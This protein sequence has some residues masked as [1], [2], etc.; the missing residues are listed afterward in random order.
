VN[1]SR[2]QTLLS[3]YLDHKLDRQVELAM[4]QHLE[5]CSKCQTTV[6]DVRELREDLRYFPEAQVS[7]ELIL[8]ILKKTSGIHEE[9]NI[10]K[11][12]VLPALR[13]FLSQR[14]AFATLMIFAFISF[15]VN[16]MGPG[17]SVSSFSPSNLMAKADRISNQIYLGWKEFNN[18]KS[19]WSEEIRLIKEDVF[20]RLDYHLITVLFESYNESLEEEDSTREETTAQES[21]EDEDTDNE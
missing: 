4:N 14:Y 6:S 3:D 9:T 20:G 13:P 2:F 21:D 15:A 17:F 11:G 10:W 1:C 7:E 19:R 18:V 8:E 16:V 5:L 12:L